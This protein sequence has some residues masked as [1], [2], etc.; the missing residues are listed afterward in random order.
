MG[1]LVLLVMELPAKAKVDVDFDPNLELARF[2]TYA[3]IGGVEHLVMLQLNPDLI[4]ERVHRALQ[5]E[6]AKKKVERS[7]AQSES[8]VE[9]GSFG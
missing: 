1:L 6:M 5:R 2:K 4:N 8:G 7:A 3:Y 9:F